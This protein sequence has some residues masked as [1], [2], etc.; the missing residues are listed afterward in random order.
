MM[1]LLAIKNA[2]MVPAAS[3][4]IDCT[5][6]AHTSSEM[7][8]PRPNLRQSE[9]SGLEILAGR[10]GPNTSPQACP[11]RHKRTLVVMKGVQ[12]KATPTPTVG[13]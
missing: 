12:E 3:L 2:F 13:E 9:A 1:S 10:Q 7:Q 11:T 4:L 6:T 8:Q 5:V